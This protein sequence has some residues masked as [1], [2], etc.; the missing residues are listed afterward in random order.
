MSE[1]K[2]GSY[3]Y[4]YRCYGTM[5][6]RSK[7]VRETKKRWVLENKDIIQKDNLKALGSSTFYKI[8]NQELK[9]KFLTEGIFRKILLDL[10][11][12]Y[13][14]RNHYDKNK[15]TL[16]TVAALRDKVQNLVFEFTKLLKDTK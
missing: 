10:D 4:Y 15:L 9:N 7:I 6:D 2:I 14:N 13:D 12:I 3:V 5:I 11:K 8:E 16:Q 1:L